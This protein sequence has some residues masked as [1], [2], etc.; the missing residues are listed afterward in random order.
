MPE[1]GVS[2][3]HPREIELGGSQALER[4]EARRF[5]G[6][7]TFE[8]LCLNLVSFFAFC[9]MAVFY[10]FFGYLER[11]G[12]PLEWRGLLVG[13]E[14]MA[15]FALRLVVIPLLHLGNAAR[16][17]LVALVMIVVALASYGWVVSLEGLMLLRVFHGAAFVL[18]V[19][20]TMAVLVHV[21]PKERSGE[22]FGI[23]SVSVLIPYAVMPP[24]TE[25]LLPH[26]G[27]EAQIYRGVTVLAAPAFL[28]LL[29]LRRR[30]RLAVAGAGGPLA[31]RPTH[32]EMR[33]NLRESRVLL[34]LTVNLLLYL[35]YATVFF[36]LKEH[37]VRSGIL[38]VA[39]FFTI[40]TLV[41]IALR[42]SGGLW[43]DKVN[44]V[45]VLG[46]FMGLLVP[47]FVLLARIDSAAML[48]VAAVAYGLCLGVVFP[49]LNAALFEISPPRLRGLNTNLALFMMD[50]GFFLSPY[51]GGLLLAAGGSASM[52]FTFGG[53]FLALNVLLLARL[54]RAGGSLQP[55][56]APEANP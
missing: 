5:N 2:P 28:I 50:A 34:L 25:A 3:S 44:K 43:F 12:I 14:P 9:N 53:G 52:L 35:C 18:L 38:R 19:S 29:G 30:I 46:V 31:R 20:S 33:G 16:A 21:I 55:K 42:L 36:F 27:S 11:I 40:S 54:G 1:G 22:G 7:Y 26:V 32:E 4:S 8:F 47:C 6:L 15:A 39:P 48:A 51:A 13:L 23:V 37:G 24:V 56:P 45:K 41:M 10:S 17:M 49:L